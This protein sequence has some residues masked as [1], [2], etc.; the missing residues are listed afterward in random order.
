MN[1]KR[2][3]NIGEAYALAKLVELGIPV[4]QQFGDNEPADY[5]I[6]VNNNLLKIQV[7]TSTTYDG[8]R[9]RFDLTSSTMHRKNG[10]RHKYSVGEVDAFICYDI[11][12]KEIF[13]IKNNGDM[14]TV[15]I[16]YSLPKNNQKEDIN[17][18]TDYALCVE[19][20]HEISLRDKEKVQTTIRK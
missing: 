4:Y 8:E 10:D 14:T 20:L 12:T 1:S 6:I 13:L 5:I 7:K 3:G 11:S 2:I 9:T 16:R 15:V 19:T 18:H 17:F